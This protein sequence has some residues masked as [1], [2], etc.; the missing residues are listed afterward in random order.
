MSI[1]QLVYRNKFSEFYKDSVHSIAYMTWLPE[2]KNMSNTEFEDEVIKRLETC[3]KQNLVNF[4]ADDRDFLFRI[5]PKIQEWVADLFSEFTIYKHA[6]IL[7][8]NIISE[9]TVD[10]T[11]NLVEKHNEFYVKAFFDKIEEAEEWLQA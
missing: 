4:L 6:M 11:L 9:I 5:E 1:K 7:P 3:K 8:V 2:T 10:Q